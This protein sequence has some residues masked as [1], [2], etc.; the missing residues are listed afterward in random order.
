MVNVVIK[1]L[2]QKQTAGIE[3]TSNNFPFKYSQKDL[4]CSKIN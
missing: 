1:H 4:P 3:S 2:K